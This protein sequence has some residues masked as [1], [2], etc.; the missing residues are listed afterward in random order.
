MEVTKPVCVHSEDSGCLHSSLKTIKLLSICHGVQLFESIEKGINMSLAWLGR[1][2]LFFGRGPITYLNT[3]VGI[4]I[5]KIDNMQEVTISQRLYGYAL[6]MCV[7][8]CT[9]L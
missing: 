6:T 2:R 4:L 9:V 3:D 7:G 5:C 1:P 8:Y